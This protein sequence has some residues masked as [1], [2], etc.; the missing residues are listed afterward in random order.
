[1]QIVEYVAGNTAG[2]LRTGYDETI[3]GSVWASIVDVDDSLGSVY[4]KVKADYVSVTDTGK[5]TAFQ[6]GLLT[7]SHPPSFPCLVMDLN[8]G[9]QRSGP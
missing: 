1:M 2:N 7:N 8:T 5:V 3:D 6:V 4:S 9:M